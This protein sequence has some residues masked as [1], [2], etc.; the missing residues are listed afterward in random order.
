M[1]WGWGLGKSGKKKPNFYSP[2]KKNSLNNSEEKKAQLNNLEEKKIHHEL[3]AG[4]RYPEHGHTC[5][6]Q[7]I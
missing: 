6:L 7:T 1:I 4:L 3:Y 2:R 5:L